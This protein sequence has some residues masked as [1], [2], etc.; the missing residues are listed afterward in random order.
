MRDQ[1]IWSVS[2]GRWYGVQLRVHMF[3]L[4]FAAFTLYLSW[5]DANAL[6]GTSGDAWTGLVCIL[7]LLLSVAIHECG[8]LLVASRLGAHLDEI[9]LGPLGG[10]GPPPTAIEPQSELVAVSAGPLANLGVCFTTAFCLALQDGAQQD[11]SV[12][13]LMHPFSP[14]GILVGDPLVVGM[15]ITF[16]VNWLLILVNL[17]PAFPFDG[18][19]ALRAALMLINPNL[20]G[21]RA[22]AVVARVAKITA[23]GL[24]LVAWLTINENPTYP[25]QTWFALVLLSIFVFFSAKKEE[26][27]ALHSQLEDAL[28]GYDFSAGYTSLEHSGPPLISTKPVTGPLVRWWK[29]RQELRAQRRRE[30]EQQEECRVDQILSQ[31]HERGLGSL[32]TEE[33][34]LLKRVSARYRNRHR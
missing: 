12:L 2:L 1:G 13:G 6:T 5:L 22:V 14:R 21:P 7:I 10:L 25:L 34:D 24:L 9:I 11:V 20:D 30:T 29:R 17:I 33:R 15:K 8:H 26:A 23:L 4:V 31:V 16:W 28:F 18:G 32:S 19:R 27:M 3:F